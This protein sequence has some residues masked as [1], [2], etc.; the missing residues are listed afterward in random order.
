MVTAET[1]YPLFLECDGV[2]TDTRKILP[3]S[4]FFAL[5]GA[6]FNGN[7][8]AQ[9]ALSKGARY[10]VIDE[11][12]YAVPG[13]TLLCDDVLTLLQ[14]LA[15]LHRNE[16]GVPIIA[17]T[18]SNGKTTTKELIQA[19]LSTQYNTVA[20]LGNLNNHI[21]VPLTLLRLTPATEYGIIEMGANHLKEI[22][23]LS[24][25]AMPDFGYITNFGKAH[26]EGFGSL[27]GVVQGKT[28]LY[29][30]LKKHHK[31]VFVNATDTTQLQH[32]E[33]VNRITFGNASA[34]IPITL[35]SE[36]PTITVAAQ[37]NTI[38]S[39]LGGVYHFGNIAAAVAIGI[40]FNVTI[41]NIKNA[42]ESYH[43]KMNRSE[44]REHNGHHIL[45][46]AYN[47]NPTS[48]QA[49]LKHFLARKAPHKVAILGDMFELGATA[50][51]EHQQ[52][53]DMMHTAAIDKVFLVGAHFAA[54]RHTAA[55]IQVF[56]T[57]DAFAQ[58]L[59]KEP[60]P[61]SHMLIKGSRGMALERALPYL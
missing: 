22:E 17:L 60:L 19:V 36:D 10:A 24:S 61:K 52:I 47:A 50:S 15:S 3:N 59:Q 57:F 7:T 58:A 45:L 55:H 12:Q 26:I 8:F 11:E 1:L 21:G 2:S 5:K 32:S 40:H 48:M 6:S 41:D 51:E 14:Q 43:P 16:L 20:T 35:A 56:E 13:K 28:E 42:I 53:V 4:L 39:Q 38:Q 9:E 23:F 46:D 49:A 25:L 54:T 37:D 18:G 44:Q 30:H 33:G 29:R 27:E 31:M 34:D